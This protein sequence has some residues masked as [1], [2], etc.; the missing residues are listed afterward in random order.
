M[1]LQALNWA[2]RQLVGVASAKAILLVLAKYADP[3]GKCWP[4]QRTLSSATELSFDTVQRQSAYLETVGFIRRARRKRGDRFSSY[5]YQLLMTNPSRA[6][7]PGPASDGEAAPTTR[8]EPQSTSPKSRPERPKVESKVSFEISNVTE[9]KPNLLA[10]CRTYLQQ[11]LDL[12]HSWFADLE[13][14]AIQSDLVTLSASTRFR[15][16][17]VTSQLEHILLRAFASCDPT[18]KRVEVIVRNPN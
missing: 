14:V 12:Y 15:R 5:T 18:V 4:S 13:F 11:D 10:A 3:A 17:Y 8:S 9:A 1:S 2:E 16:H 6:A 7:L